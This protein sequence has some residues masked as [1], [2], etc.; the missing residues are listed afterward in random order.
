LARGVVQIAGEL[1]ELTVPEL[2]ILL[3][4]D[5]RIAER[6]RPELA[7]PHPPVAADGG[8]ASSSQHAQ[9]FRYR[10]E[11]HVEGSRQV[12]DGRISR[13]E[14]RQEGAPG[15]IGEGGEGAVEGRLRV[16]HMV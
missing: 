6:I 2:L 9:V 14:P 4:P 13:G 15:G 10:R 8:E 1:V 7:A 5:R 16:N 3:D 11:R 12:A